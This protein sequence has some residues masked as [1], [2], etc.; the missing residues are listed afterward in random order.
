MNKVN[1]YVLYQSGETVRSL[2]KDGRLKEAEALVASL[3]STR[4]E[5]VMMMMTSKTA[6]RLS[7]FRD[8]MFVSRRCLKIR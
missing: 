7:L 5:R 6:V 8:A 3:V 1:G 4:D 2:V